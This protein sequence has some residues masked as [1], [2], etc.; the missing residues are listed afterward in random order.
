MPEAVAAMMRVYWARTG[1]QPDAVEG[2]ILRTLFEA[3]GYEVE[4]QSA[5]FDAALS[6][7]IPEAVYAAFGFPRRQARA[8]NVTLR[9][10][11]ATPSGSPY[12]IP[13]G[14]LAETI[15][16][17]RFATTADVTLAAATLTVDVVAIA[18][19]AG[20]AGNVPA[21][22]IT[23][24]ATL[25]PGVEGVTNPTAA[26]GGEDREDDLAQQTRFASYLATLAKGT[27]PA[28]VAAALTVERPDRERAKQALVVDA[29]DDPAIPIGE[30]VTYVYRPGGTSLALRDAILA[31][32]ELTQRPV[33][34]KIT[35]EEVTPVP[36]TLTVT[37]HSMDTDSEA[38]AQTSVNA[39][40]DALSIGEDVYAE[41]IE[42]AIVAG[43][44]AAYRA[45]VTI[46]G[47]SPATIGAYERAE[48][49]TLTITRSETTVT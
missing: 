2:G 19:E 37:V 15:A 13:E 5:R 39:H 1:V 47:G 18:V 26:F 21:T 16:G 14:T 32:L 17:T 36:I 10:S 35:V 9:F 43:D 38:A 44:S 25:V 42:A 31:H 28:M 46:T 24:V 34:V 6:E 45:T 23:R 29:Y 11:R 3:W 30:A 49:G 27:A 12:L 22:T 4:Q 8:A 7:G 20:A 48:V 41:R 40:F 33:G